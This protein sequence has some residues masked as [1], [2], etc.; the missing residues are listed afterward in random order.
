MWS[1][2]FSVTGVTVAAAARSESAP[3]VSG[4]WP[5]LPGGTEDFQSCDVGSGL[6]RIKQKSRQIKHFL[7]SSSSR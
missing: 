7:I 2:N 6:W 1:G 3:G 5:R 4:K